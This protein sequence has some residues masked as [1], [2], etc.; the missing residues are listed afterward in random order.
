MASPMS[1]VSAKSRSSIALAPTS[2]STPAPKNSAVNRKT[3]DNADAEDGVRKCGTPGCTLGAGHIGLCESECTSGKR[4]HSAPSADPPLPRALPLERKSERNAAAALCY[5]RHVGAD[6][7]AAKVAETRGKGPQPL[8]ADEARAAAAA[9]GLE[10]LPSSSNETGFK[11]VSK[12]HGKYKAEVKENGMQH[13]LGTFATPE[14][15]ALCYAKRIGA[16][17]A[18]ARA[19]EARGEYAKPLTA[20]EA[21]AAAAAEGLELVPS[22]TSDTGFRNVRFIDGK[23]RA[24]IREQGKKRHLGTFATPEEAALC[25]ARHIGAERVAA[26]VAEA[27]VEKPQ[28]LTAD[29][30]RAAAAAEGLE[31]V[32]SSSGETGFRGV[33]KTDGM[34]QAHI[35]ADGKHRHLGTFATPEEAALC[36]ARFVAAARSARSARSAAEAAEARGDGLQPLTA[37][38]A[39]AAA[40]AE[41]R[42]AAA[43]EGLE[44][45]PSSSGETGFKGVT[46]SRDK[47]AAKVGE[48]GKARFLGTF[49]T[50]EEAALCYARYIGA[51]RGWTEAAEARGDA[52]AKDGVRRRRGRGRGHANAEDGVRK[53]G[54]PG[55]T[56]GAGH[57]G[58]CES[59]CTPGKRR[60]SSQDSAPSAKCT[61][62]KKRR[63]SAQDSA[64]SA[65]LRQP[66]TRSRQRPIR[67][68][69]G[70]AQAEGEGEEEEE[71]EGEEE[72]EEEEEGEGEGEG[73]GEEEGG[74]EGE[75]QDEDEDEDE[76]EDEDGVGDEDEESGD[77]IEGILIAAAKKP[78]NVAKKAA[79]EREEREDGGDDE[80]EHM[81][82]REEEESTR[83]MH[84]YFTRTSR[85]HGALAKH[86]GVCEERHIELP[87]LERHLESVNVDEDGIDTTAHIDFENV[88]VTYVLASE[89]L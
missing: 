26:E 77:E 36:Y 30:A 41:A 48:D 88:D 58:L 1:P 62:G 52:K 46:K 16:E 83:L 5:S 6:R 7:A 84:G 9:E 12:H 42:A 20:D 25:Y 37:G 32:P 45:V 89:C 23:Y 28:M 40:A 70:E 8:T 4:R 86:I 39:R 29:E 24:Q 73:E 76:E 47:Y 50:P 79:N 2:S 78:P 61:R 22:P 51:G 69:C 15:A 3:K 11:G 74:D 59:E 49:A 80:D 14:E 44:L 34:Y 56:L 65:V 38:E 57:I 71:E 67:S 17:R 82:K 87:N 33:T 63:H 53:C 35:R 60:R 72:E 54:T 75:G 64:L 43:A 10:L 31:L 19:A 66:R 27:R 21:R 18:A 13:H 81:D 68:K 85:F 55:C